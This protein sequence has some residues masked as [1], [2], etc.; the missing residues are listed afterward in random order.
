M[1]N[2]PFNLFVYGT[3]MNP[4]VF[5]AVTG[6]R[7]VKRPA[8]ADGE[9]SFRAR[10]AILPGYKKISPD[11]TYL[12]AVP[13][14][15]G[16]IR[17]Y[18]IGPLSGET[19]SALLQYEGRNYSRRTVKVQTRTGPEKATVFVGNVKQLAHA[20]G[21]DFH[22]RLK[23]EIILE[24]KIEAALVETEQQQLH[25]SSEV[26]RRAVA[27][28]HG[29]TIRDLR[30]RHFEAGGISDYAIRRSLMD[31]PLPDFDRIASDPEARA[32]APNYLAMVIRQVIFNQFEDRIRK[33]FRYEIEQLSPGSEY[34]DRATSALAALRLVN[35]LSDKL[36]MMI[37]DAVQDL[38]L[39]R[40]HLVDCV[41]LVDPGRRRTLRHS[42]RPPRG[43]V[44]PAAQGPGLHP[45]WRGAGVLE[46]RARGH[47]RSRR[48]GRPRPQLRRV[49]VLPGLRAQRADVE[50]R[51]A[52]GRP[53]RQGVRRAAPG[54][55]RGGAGQPVDLG[56]HLQ[57]ADR[58]PVV[59][60][61][62][63]PPGP[64][65]LPH[66]AAQRAHLAPAPAPAE[67]RPGP[68]AAA[69]DAQVPL[70]HRRRSPRRNPTDESGSAGSTAR[71]S[72]PASPSPT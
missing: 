3:L 58:R 65:V 5:R 12:Y 41:Q 40:D 2:R 48:P 70:R 55:L 26:L 1:A 32:L 8:E 31:V 29:S 60:Q 30:R 22:D 51:R 46:H 17:G 20:F 69:V 9:T 13:E 72:D 28:L 54:V 21:Y 6:L 23:Q 35:S 44:H 71:K 7:L 63:H 43:A 67:P 66:H 15:H 38:D 11:H 57:A 34:Y 18:L 4:E 24:E 10:R 16:R 42:L 27:E 25:R 47:Q 14:R 62:V 68:P 61:P 59:P 49:P 52:R 33:D 36:E 53:S 37:T 56:E 39:S 50:A 19:L 45:H 64:Q